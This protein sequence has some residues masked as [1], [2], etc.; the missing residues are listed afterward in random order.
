MLI[1]S[2]HP[3][4][5]YSNFIAR[6]KLFKSREVYGDPTLGKK[7]KFARYL[8]APNSGGGRGGAKFAAD[9]FPRPLADG[10]SRAARYNYHEPAD[11]L[12]QTMARA[13]P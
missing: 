13:Q 1:A 4:W 6:V 8:G 9:N 5:K 7:R 2:Q 3:G 11:L 12:P 10:V